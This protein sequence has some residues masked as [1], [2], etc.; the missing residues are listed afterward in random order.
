[1][2]NVIGPRYKRGLQLN[3]ATAQYGTVVYCL[4][5]LSRYEYILLLIECLL[6]CR[7]D[8]FIRVGRIIGIAQSHIGFRYDHILRQGM[9]V[10][11]YRLV[12]FCILLRHLS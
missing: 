10:D 1:M 5:I 12:C 9:A 8:R 2:L 6:R 7:T 3:I 4:D 11:R